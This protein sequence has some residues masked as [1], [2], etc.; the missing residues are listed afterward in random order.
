MD[1]LILKML[2]K[3]DAAIINV[4]RE[5]SR[6]PIREIAKRSQL[7]PSTVHQ[8]LL[9]L[10]DQG[11]IEKFTIKVNDDAIGQNFIVLMLVKTKPTAILDDSIIKNK[12]VKEV[13]GITGEYDIL[14]KLKFKDINEFNNYIIRFRKEQ[15]IINTLTMISTAK[16][17][18][19][20]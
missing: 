12:H 19:E 8:R 16:I 9:K 13:F 5:N 3:K 7:R 6:M 14:M 18:E 10:K 15:K 1:N 4:L 11:I 20:P 2:A 17:K